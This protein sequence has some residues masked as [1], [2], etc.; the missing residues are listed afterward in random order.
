MCACQN[1][2]CTRYNRFFKG[3]RHEDC[4]ATTNQVRLYFPLLNSRSL[5]VPSLFYTAALESGRLSGTMLSVPSE[6]RVAPAVHVG[7]AC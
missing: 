2:S 6:R 4:R 3:A 1:E 5:A 7:P